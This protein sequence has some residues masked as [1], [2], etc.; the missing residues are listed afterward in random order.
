M[1]KKLEEC[2]II[3]LTQHDATADQKAAGVIDIRDHN[4]DYV[5]ELLTFEQLP[6]NPKLVFTAADLA[7]VAHNELARLGCGPR[8][9]KAMIGGAPYLMNYLERA[10]V[11]RGIEPVYAFTLRESVETEGADG[12]VFVKRVFKHIGFVRPCKYGGPE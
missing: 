3:N 12:K 6:D 11:N 9:G 7:D 4:R 5:R 8:Y 2:R 10:L 1:Y